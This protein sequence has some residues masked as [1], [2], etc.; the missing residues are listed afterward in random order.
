M[1]TNI[2]DNILI[3]ALEKLIS[4]KKMLKKLFSYL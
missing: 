3:I 4:T 2:T 1:L